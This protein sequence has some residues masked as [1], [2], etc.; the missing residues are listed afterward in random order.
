M[1]SSLPPSLSVDE[2]ASTYDHQQYLSGRTCTC[3]P[4][5]WR[6]PRGTPAARTSII[7]GSSGR[8]LSPLLPPPHT[9]TEFKEEGGGRREKE[10]YLSAPQLLI[11]WRARV[12]VRLAHE[13]K[14]RARDGLLAQRRSRGRETGG[15]SD[16]RGGTGDGAEGGR[17]NE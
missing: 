11:L 10:T 15:S 7:V 17:E 13:A 12:F 2:E 16:A 4:R 6:Q 1:L 9:R 5:R 14:S 3:S 8:Q